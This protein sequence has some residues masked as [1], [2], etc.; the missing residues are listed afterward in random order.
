M[1][2]RPGVHHVPGLLLSNSYLLQEPAG[3]TLIDAGMPWD[4]RKILRYIERIGRHPA[5]LKRI[6]LTH[7]HPDHTGPL[8]DLCRQSGAPV[9]VH[10]A[11]TMDR[12]KRGRPWLFYPGQFQL[13]FWNVPL[14][15]RIP[16]DDTLRDGQVLPVLG[17]LEVVHTPGHTPGSVCFYLRSQGV[18]FTGD[19]L[20]ANGPIFRRP[21]FFPGSNLRDYRES[22]ERLACLEFETTCFGHGAPLTVGGT[23]SLREMLEDY[24]WMAPRWKALK[25]WSRSLLGR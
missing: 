10:Q 17:G 18:L 3:L 1:E 25:G 24:S 14:F 5:E 11:D 12:G 8:P 16:Y 7:S 20:L 4:G 19:M 21:V 23:A 9:A 22:V 15:R 13:P 2:I 6:L